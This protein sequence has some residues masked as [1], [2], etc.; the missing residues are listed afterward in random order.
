MAGA[1]RRRA[2]RAHPLAVGNRGGA[3]ARPSSGNGE[4]DFASVERLPLPALMPYAGRTTFAYD[5]RSSSPRSPT[6]W[7][8][9]A[10][11]A[12]RHS[13]IVE[14]SWPFDDGDDRIVHQ[15]GFDHNGNQRRFE[16]GRHDVTYTTFDQFD[17]A[18]LQDL[19]GKNDTAREIT[20]FEYDPNGLRTQTT[21]PANR[22]WEQFYDALYQL[23]IYEDALYRRTIYTYTQRQPASERTPLGHLT[24]YEYDRADRLAK[25]IDPRGEETMRRYDPNGNLLRL[26][27]LGRAH[28]GEDY[29]RQV[30]PWTYEGRDLMWT[31]TKGPLTHAWEYDGGGNLR[32]SIEP[33]GIN[34][35]TGRPR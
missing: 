21:T 4:G 19:P 22:V 34:S 33:T 29:R 7:G 28:A 8:R 31:M 18:T 25:T 30:T 1:G 12:R 17:R 16:N 2:G 27:D 15:F 35:D 9:R 32:R 13:R 14:I 10:H 24:R 23:S 26:E 6:S 3:S 20:R 5:T 11:R